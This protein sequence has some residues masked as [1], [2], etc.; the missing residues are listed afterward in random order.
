MNQE[1]EPQMNT[2]ESEVLPDQTAVEDANA[3]GEVE[4]EPE[5]PP[6]PVY[7]GPTPGEMLRAEREKR[8]LSIED[9]VTQSRMSMETVKAL[10]EDRDP[11]QN[12]WVYVRGYYR[13]YARVLGI[14][15]D[16]LLAAHERFSGGAPEPEPV[17]AEWAPEDVSP[18]GG[19][20]K[21]ILVLIAGI[22]FG[23]LLWWAVPLVK[24]EKDGAEN[25]TQQL[26]ID[27]PSDRST[28]QP[29][30]SS[31]ANSK[32]ILPP[33]APETG[34]S[35]S[36][37]VSEPGLSQSEMISAV[38]TAA[39]DTESSQVDSADP[40]QGDESALEFG[41]G[42]GIGDGDEVA[43]VQSAI[44]DTEK[45]GLEFSERSWVNVV[46]ATGKKL[47][48][49]IVRGGASFALDGQPPYKVFLGYAPGVIVSF[50]GRQIDI[51][52]HMTSNNTARFTVT[53]ETSSVP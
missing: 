21:I 14:S 9:V 38:T 44:R 19:V 12:A 28:N 41:T 40:G 47:L 29:S 25:G 31:A 24:G 30:D 50:Q 32:V 26:E 1:Q 3:G 17:S 7:T 23:G 49:G 20:P 13:K 53:S 18:T 42:T 6:Q 48:D 22:L 33:V 52:R 5:L 10:E 11:P 51:S 37:E 34:N 35:S 36:E 43:D 27:K 8:D 46:D 16:E 4:Q 2:S 15:E 39:Q 45:L